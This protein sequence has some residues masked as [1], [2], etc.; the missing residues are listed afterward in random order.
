MSRGNRFRQAFGAKAKDG[1][2]A[3]GRS[4]HRGGGGARDGGDGGKRLDAAI[5]QLRLL[6]DAR[7]RDLSPE[8]VREAEQEIRALED[9]T[10]AYRQTDVLPT[11][12]RA[13]V[14][15][16]ALIRS[17]GTRPACLIKDGCLLAPE[18]LGE[19][20]D[21]YRIGPIQFDEAFA[22]TGR[23]SDGRR[24]HGGG[25]LVRVE[26][27]D[28]IEE[29]VLTAR[30][31]VQ[32][33]ASD[34]ATLRFAAGAEIDFNGEIGSLRPN[35]HRLA[36]VIASGPDP[37]NGNSAPDAWDFALVRLGEPIDGGTTPPPAG[38]GL[39]TYLVEDNASAA[40]VS[41]PGHPG[42]RPSQLMPG[43]IWH[44]LF[45]GLWNV[46]RFSPATLLPR[47]NDG[48]YANLKP[49]MMLHDATTTG[50]SS[51][52]ALLAVGSGQVAGV[53]VGG[54]A[55]TA[56]LAVRLSAIADRC[57]WRAAA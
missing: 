23:I 21:L 5:E 1:F 33:I 11:D 3:E 37:I 47:P 10:E 57:G 19:L 12:D 35:R 43:T 36:E 16:E 7:R 39:Q 44:Q 2:A 41:F 34:P 55:E 50:G 56:N 17:D 45:Q 9:V 27:A 20:G 18:A 54:R 8:Q 40:V 52:G 38:I 6:L 26:T 51:G 15:L 14:R 31:V 49:H 30:H 48:D 25:C 53:H 29:G 24:F 46:K 4:L 42:L 22:A 32:A 13:Q 28:G